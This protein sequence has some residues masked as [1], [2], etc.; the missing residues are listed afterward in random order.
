MN[1][2]RNQQTGWKVSSKAKDFVVDFAKRTRMGQAE[3]ADYILCYLSD[4]PDTIAAPTQYAARIVPTESGTAFV[5]K[6]Q[7]V[8]CGE[9]FDPETDGETVEALAKWTESHRHEPA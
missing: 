3:A 5:L 8:K 6:C 2:E 9:I 7:E 1:T 4:F